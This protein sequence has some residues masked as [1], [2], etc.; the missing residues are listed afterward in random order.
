MAFSDICCPTGGNFASDISYTV[1][2]SPLVLGSLGGGG[3]G[4][5]A[6][7]VNFS[8]WSCQYKKSYSEVTLI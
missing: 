7:V 3:G 5:L 6:A 1:N 8:N 2:S 4:G